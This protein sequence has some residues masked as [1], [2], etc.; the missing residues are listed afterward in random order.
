VENLSL[1]ALWPVSSSTLCTSLTLLRAI[2]QKASS[3]RMGSS[4]CI[5]EKC[6]FRV[7]RNFTNYTEPIWFRGLI[8]TAKIRGPQIIVLNVVLYAI[9][10]P[11][12]LSLLVW[13][14]SR[15][16]SWNL[17]CFLTIK[18]LPVVKLIRNKR[19]VNIWPSF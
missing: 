17:H 15:K 12:D 3:T 18:P 16:I 13:R 11:L 5:S 4:N 8:W 2:P 19:F 6:N 9:Y 7:Q 1:L 10:G 14:I